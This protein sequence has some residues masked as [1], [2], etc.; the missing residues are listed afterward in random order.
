MATCGVRRGAG[1]SRAG[2]LEF[3]ADLLDFVVDRDRLS[4]R[5]DKRAVV[6]LLPVERAAPLPVFDGIGAVTDGLPGHVAHLA[7]VERV[8][9]GRQLTKAGSVS[10]TQKFLCLNPR[11]RSCV[12][13]FVPGRSIGSR[14]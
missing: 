14:M 6:L 10:I 12:A 11:V 5:A 1:E 4:R 8:L 13:P 7:L 2:F 3:R 9:V